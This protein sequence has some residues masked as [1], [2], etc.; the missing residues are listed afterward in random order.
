MRPIPSNYENPDFIIEQLLDT[1][2]LTHT[3]KNEVTRSTASP[4]LTA[5]NKGYWTKV[6][7]YTKKLMGKLNADQVVVITGPLYLPHDGSKGK[8]YVSYQIIGEDNI[9]VPTHFFKA[10]FY[11]L[12]TSN[13]GVF[14]TENEIYIIPNEDL[15][16]KLPLESFKTSLEDFEKRAGILFPADISDYLI[17]FSMANLPRL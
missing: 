3:S 12:E 8:R 4:Q 5:F 11:P 9:A 15:D 2:H 7:T 6:N 1:S 14:S 17:P 16:E 10:I 13:Q